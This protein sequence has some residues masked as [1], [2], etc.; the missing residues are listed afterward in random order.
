MTFAP[1]W[2]EFENALKYL[3]QANTVNL[4]HVHV[5]FGFFVYPRGESKFCLEYL[6]E[7][8]DDLSLVSS[9]VESDE[10]LSRTSISDI[11]S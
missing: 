11:E 9:D 5:G 7:M 3:D 6:A 2:R 10:V 1:P 4:N 8:F